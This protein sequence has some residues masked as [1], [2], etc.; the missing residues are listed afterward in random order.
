MNMWKKV[1]EALV[2][3]VQ[4][5]KHE[6]EDKLWE[7]F[8]RARKRREAKEVW[9]HA[10]QRSLGEVAPRVVPHAN[11]AGLHKLATS[12]A[13]NIRFTA[14]ELVDEKLMNLAV[15]A[16]EMG[17]CDRDETRAYRISLSGKAEGPWFME[18]G[19]PMECDYLPTDYLKHAWV[20]NPSAA[21]FR[22]LKP[23]KTGG[24]A[25]EAS[26]KT[27]KVGERFVLD[28]YGDVTIVRVEDGFV[29]V[30]DSKGGRIAMTAEEAR[31]WLRAAT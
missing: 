5:R 20:Q 27:V 7:A 26:A 6:A 3:I 25:L 2:D 11:P 21:V 15:A 8:D 10:K 23:V 13:R 29:A 17:V 22:V 31:S 12:Y 30:E 9:Q 1:K 16:Y 4:A 19:R 18:G 14:P 28:E 24:S